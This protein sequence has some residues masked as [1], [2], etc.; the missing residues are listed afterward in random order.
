MYEFYFYIDILQVY[1]GI[2]IPMSFLAFSPRMGSP[3]STL[4][5]RK[6]G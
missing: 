6:T 4:L 2:L 1:I 3:P 5:V